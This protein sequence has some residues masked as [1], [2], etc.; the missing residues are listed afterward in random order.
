MLAAATAGSLLTATVGSAGAA[1][2]RPA[3]AAKPAA[4]AIVP[5]VQLA[6][7]SV[8]NLGPAIPGDYL[9]ISY[10]AA[11]ISLPQWDPTQ[12]NLARLLG[13]LG[14]G[15]IR[16]GGSTLD[17]GTVWTSLLYSS[18]PSWAVSTVTRADLQRLASFAQASG[19]RIILGV[20]L[21]HYDPQR[22]ADEART[23]Q[24]VLG[25]SLVGVE[26]GNE[27]EA[28]VTYGLR[29]G[30]NPPGCSPAIDPSCDPGW[31][32]SDSNTGTE[33]YPYVPGGDPFAAYTY[34]VEAYR[35]AIQSAAP[36]LAVI[37]PAS[38]GAGYIGAYAAANGV[39]GQAMTAHVYAAQVC[40][41]S[42]APAPTISDILG[43]AV[44][45]LID[46]LVKTDV[47]IGTANGMPVRIAETN[48]IGCGG[49]DGVSNTHASAL[50]AANMLG[51]AATDGAAG[52]NFHA[53]RPGVCGETTTPW[54]TPICATTSDD[55]ANGTF[56]AQP[57][58]YAMALYG[59][60]TG[61][62]VIP[63]LREARANVRA[64]ATVDAAGVVRVLVDDMA[65]AGA[66]I[67]HLKLPPTFGVA[68]E[69]L[70]AGLG[71]D[72]RSGTTYGGQTARSDG[73][74]GPIY[75]VSVPDSAGDLIYTQPSGSVA[76][77]TL[78]QA[79]TLPKAVG[80]TLANATK[81]LT[82]RGCVLGAVKKVKPP[83]RH[84]PFL[85]AAQQFPAGRVV[86]FQQPVKL[87]LV[88]KPLPAPKR[89]RKKPATQH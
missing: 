4:K 59:A 8:T 75:P 57:E 84:K 27:P 88:A 10:E 58:W 79:C 80:L 31:P 44:T 18:K 6:I 65:A 53:G 71:L 86:A 13:S 35:N 51:L 34:Q 41:G 17:T 32:A 40:P 19:W 22:A 28:F 55:L 73:T 26:L 67:V 33:S 7:P 48:N 72:A 82:Q 76:V 68:N 50:W 43:G 52:V 16:F 81:A 20:N 46:K 77:L 74:F 11:A 9:G 23:A 45:G 14:P 3:A 47:A 29:P 15:I 2:A 1:T 36:G 21:G 63:I 61:T 66:Q 12:S 78:S 83:K 49:E 70:L 89:P 85:V 24:Q 56:T 37:G 54:Y 62:R 87:R 25:A 42:T 69:T 60:F 39:S 64:Y 30:A 5:D 38:N